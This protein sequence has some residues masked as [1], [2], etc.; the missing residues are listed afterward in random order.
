MTR[1]L[2][3]TAFTLT[4]CAKAPAT[5]TPA[6][7]A[8]PEQTKSAPSEAADT[9]SF[10]APEDKPLCDFNANARECLDQR[11]RWVGTIPSMLLAHPDVSGPDGPSGVQSYIDV[12]GQQYILLVPEIP[13]CTDGI[14]ATGTLKEIDLGGP[15]GTRNSYR[16]YYLANA[17]VRCTDAQ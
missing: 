12:D 9:Q 11:V 8:P 5:E 4:A 14:E 6:P 2:I 7:T 16:N 15:E 1:P 10:D 13:T 3:W 17:E